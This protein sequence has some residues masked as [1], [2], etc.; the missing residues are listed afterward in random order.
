MKKWIYLL[1]LLCTFTLAKAQKNY[2]LSA[3]SNF[4]FLTNRIGQ[5]DAGI[6]LSVAANA[7]AKRPLQLK[8]EASLDHFIGDK[9]LYRDAFGNDY[10]SNPTM[11]NFRAGPEFFINK[12]SIAALYGY[13]SYK[14]YDY[15]VHSG[16]F[17]VAFAVRPPKHSKMLVG[18]Y[19]TT[20]TGKYSDVHFWGVNLGF[21]IL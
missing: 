5:N 13:V 2:S 21:K 15:K 1:S 6:G 18:A 9:L 11:L 8:A 7:F 4:S 10:P 20:L 17:K 14:L 19:F 12:I 16:N 3:S